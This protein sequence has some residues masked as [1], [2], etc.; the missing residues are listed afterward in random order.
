LPDER[1]KLKKKK[2]KKKNLLARRAIKLGDVIIVGFHY[3]T[4]YNKFK[5][6]YFF[7]D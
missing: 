7:Q 1:K 3:C 5:G 2:K 4:V 6:I